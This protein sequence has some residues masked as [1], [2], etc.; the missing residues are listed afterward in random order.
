VDIV[1]A[2]PRP[3]RI[4]KLRRVIQR[5]RHILS[6]VRNCDVL[7]QRVEESLARKRTAHRESWEAFKDYVSEQR[8]D[9]YQK[10]VGKLSKINLSAFYVRLRE[11]L[12]APPIAPKPSD[13]ASSGGPE[14]VKAVESEGLKFQV[15][16]A[17]QANLEAFDTQVANAQK[18][19]EPRVLHPVRIAA[20]KLRY[21]IEVIHELGAPDTDQILKQLKGLQQNLGDWHDMEVMEQMMADMLARP[22][23]LLKNINLAMKTE[24]LMLRNQ[25]IKAAHEKKY[26]ETSLDPEAWSRLKTWVENLPSTPPLNVAE[27]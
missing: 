19:T 8:S 13:V 6:T 4:R 12:Q 17:L 1:Y 25:K 22:A 18:E 3:K 16:R 23:F 26:L 9:N 11:S 15:F 27:P 5:S 7:M 14:F 21:L 2:A 20:K 24:R 10:A